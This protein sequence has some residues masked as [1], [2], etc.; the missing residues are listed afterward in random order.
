MVSFDSLW[1]RWFFRLVRLQ[2]RSFRSFVN[3]C[4][5]LRWTIRFL[6]VAF[7]AV[8]GYSLQSLGI[9]SFRSSR[10]VFVGFVINSS[11]SFIASHSSWLVTVLSVRFY[12]FLF[13]I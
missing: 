13:L 5:P 8:V 4:E 11:M 12:I 2:V 3:L 9:R 10:W 6:F 1:F 7:V